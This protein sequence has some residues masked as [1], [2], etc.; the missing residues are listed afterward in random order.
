MNTY[1]RSQ[2][3]AATGAAGVSGQFPAGGEP[4]PVVGRAY[5]RRGRWSRL[6]E[7]VL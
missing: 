4:A 2:R 3:F 1:R 5:Q 6:A 7:R